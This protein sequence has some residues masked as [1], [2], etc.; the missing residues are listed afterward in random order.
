M[1]TKLEKNITRESSIKVDDRE[2]MVTLTAD[3]EISFKLKGMRSGEVKISIEEIY[4]QLTGT[5][6]EGGGGAVVDEG[7]GNA[8][9]SIV[10][11]HQGKKR[12]INNPMIPLK[13]L[14]SYNAISSL[15]YP[16]LCKFEG[17]IVNL[18]ENYSENYVK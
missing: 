3:Q 2:I 13:D 5:H 1:A 8:S 11:S 10:I 16:T 17:I 12:K 18:L 7:A 14:R 4:G 9:G 15:D 6:I